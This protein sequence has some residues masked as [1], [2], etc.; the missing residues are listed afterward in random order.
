MATT[1]KELIE[2]ELPVH[3]SI[4][5]EQDMLTI[6]EIDDYE[7]V[8]NAETVPVQ[9]F[10]IHASRLQRPSLLDVTLSYYLQ[11]PQSRG[12][13]IKLEGTAD[14]EDLFS[15]MIGYAFKLANDLAATDVRVVPKDAVAVLATDAW[16]K[17]CYL[18]PIDNGGAP[19]VWQCKD[20][21]PM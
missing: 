19:K 9:Y 1:L 5:P 21:E 17:S 13:M 16:Q 20:L 15:R 8:G 4:S 18:K 12:S 7:S 11:H 3:T 2:S 14:T 6:K 10:I